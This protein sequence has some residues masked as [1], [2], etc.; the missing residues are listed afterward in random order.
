MKVKRM[1]PNKTI[2]DG[3]LKSLIEATIFVANK[4]MSIQMLKQSILTDY[5]VTKKR[6]MSSIES[7]M[8]EYQDRGIVLKKVGSGYRFQAISEFSDDLSVLFKEKTPRYSRALLETLSLIAYKQP[9]TRGEIENI[10]GVAVSS[11]IINT[12]LE[13]EWVKSVGHKDVPGRP[14]LYGTTHDFL[15]YFSLASLAELPELTVPNTEIEIPELENL[16]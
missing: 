16:N 11:H 15:D 8:T 6:I 4:P 14:A 7:L 1:I 5:N 3:K 13:R 9:I 2:T 10:R 12:L